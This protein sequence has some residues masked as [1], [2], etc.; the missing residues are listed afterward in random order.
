VQTDALVIGRSYAF[1]EKRRAGKPL[2]KVKLI[3]VVGR[4]GKVKI[5]FEEGPHPGLEEFV[6]TRKLSG[7]LGGTKGAASRRGACGALG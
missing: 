1:R 6:S 3:D 7:P 4:K 5:R 2:L